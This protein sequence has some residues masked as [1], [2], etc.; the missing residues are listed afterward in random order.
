MADKTSSQAQ[1]DVNPLDPMALWT[2][3]TQ[4]HIARIQAY[5]DELA[6]F[7]AKAYERAKT[8]TNQLADLA[9]ESITY[10]SKL[11]AEWREMTIEAT[12][13]GVEMFRARA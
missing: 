3:M 2:R 9:N 1:H 10:A 5:Y 13:R 4:D 8:A 11:A 12:K 7:E 6:G